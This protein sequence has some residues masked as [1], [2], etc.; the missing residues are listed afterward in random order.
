TM[1]SDDEKQIETYHF[2]HLFDGLPVMQ[3]FSLSTD[4]GLPSSYMAKCMAM[5]LERKIANRHSLPGYYTS[6][7]SAFSQSLLTSVAGPFDKTSS[8]KRYTKPSSVACGAYIF[9]DRDD[10]LCLPPLAPAV[11]QTVD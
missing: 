9:R 2:E 6:W 1:I 11:I 8:Q 3:C 7:S 10:L 5:S 4:P